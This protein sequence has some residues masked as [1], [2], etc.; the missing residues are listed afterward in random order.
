MNERKENWSAAIQNLGALAAIVIL[1]MSDKISG[2]WAAGM[3]LSVTGVIALPAVLKG[4]K[5]T[6]STSDGPQGGNIGSLGIIALAG[7]SIRIVLAALT[8][9]GKL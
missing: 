3:I 9:V 7:P 8:G 4:G 1:A 6:G 5:S 2:E